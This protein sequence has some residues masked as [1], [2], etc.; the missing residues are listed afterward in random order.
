MAIPQERP[1]N[2]GIAR[3]MKKP[4][5]KAVRDTITGYAFVAPALFGF[6]VFTL[7]PVAASLLIGI[8]FGLLAAV[9][10]NSLVDRFVIGVSF[11][12][13]AVPGFFREVP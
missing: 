5:K 4:G 1:I 6:C 2:Q 3:F 11:I 10:R 7:F 9:R 12:G 8:P 13:Q